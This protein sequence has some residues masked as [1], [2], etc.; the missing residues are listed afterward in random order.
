M[1]PGSTEAV[2]TASVVADVS[3]CVWLIVELGKGASVRVGGLSEVKAIILVRGISEPVEIPGRKQEES[4]Q[5]LI[6]VAS[7]STVFIILG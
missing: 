2:V 7:Y 4:K 6:N 1:T 3:V 5:Y